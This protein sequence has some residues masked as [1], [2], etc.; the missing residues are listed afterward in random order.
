FDKPL[1]AAGVAT[2]DELARF[3]ASTDLQ[4]GQGVTVLQGRW[5][6]VLTNAPTASAAATLVNQ[7]AEIGYAASSLGKKAG[8]RNVFEVRI[9]N[10]ATPEDAKWVLDKLSAMPALG[11]TAG[12]V[13]LAAA[14]SSG[15]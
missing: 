1:Q 9:S 10:F 5:R 13:A 12:R 8:A 11:I 2:Q 7:L 4:P 14:S 6:A 15:Q 3:I